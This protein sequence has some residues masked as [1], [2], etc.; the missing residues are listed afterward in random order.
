MFY[1]KKNKEKIFFLIS[2]VIIILNLIV[3]PKKK[4]SYNLHINTEIAKGIII[5]EKDE[6]LEKEVDKNSFPIEYNFS[7]KNFDNNNV[8]DVDFDYKIKIESSTAIFPIK[9]KLIDVDNNCEIPLNFGETQT[10]TLK[11]LK[12]EVRNFKLYVEWND[13]DSELSDEVEIKLKIQAVQSREEGE[14][15]EEV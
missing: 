9:Y 10:L 5:L 8:N 13:L 6:F 7:I 15:E 14:Y 2:L 12:K 11:K 1:V 4:F 3:L